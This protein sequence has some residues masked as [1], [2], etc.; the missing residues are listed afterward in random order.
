MPSATD[1]APPPVARP[2]RLRKFT[3]L[4][5][6]ALALLA[7]L[8]VGFY[9]V[10]K[11]RGRALWQRYEA[12]ARV[13]GVKLMLADYVPPPVPDAKNFAVIPL[14]E[15]AFRAQAAGHAAPNPFALPRLAGAQQ[16]RKSPPP[17]PPLGQPEKA[18]VVDLA[19]WQRFFV[20]TKALPAATDNAAAD[21]MKALERYAE[22]LEQ[23][24]AAGAR[25]ACRFP[26][27]WEDGIHAALPHL[28]M[29]R[30]AA[31]IYALRCAAHLALGDSAA[32]YEDFRGVLR[33]YTATAQEPSLIAGLA[34]VAI[35]TTAE[36]AV[37]TGL[38]GRQWADAE[39]RRIGDD[40][41]PLRLFADYR[42]GMSSERGFSN[43]IHEQLRGMSG[44]KIHELLTTASAP[45][46]PDQASVNGQARLFSAFPCG[47][48]YRSQERANRYF[49]EMLERVSVEPPRVF[50]E[51]VVKSG[52]EQL[53]GTSERLRHLFFFLL[54]PALNSVEGT[55]ARAQTFTDQTRLACA[56]ELHRRAHGAF[57][58]T[59][60]AL[61]PALL[62]ALLRDV[63]NGEPLRYRVTEGG[64]YLLYSVA[65]NLADDGGKTGPEPN[66]H[67][68]DWVWRMP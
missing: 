36:N 37:W 64:G 49:D 46:P 39:L 48:I 56:L 10:E 63:M 40:L 66:K 26:V 19:A 47:W 59:L 25:P 8:I 24:R 52:P 67:Q 9:V 7:T 53:V 45:T 14:F 68:P 22:P 61:A 31:K 29:L 13:R 60:D 2:S 58:A 4:A 38:F 21:V 20:E 44:A 65:W 42:L 12:E 17:P 55:Y 15:E 35:L 62:P 32:A 54:A 1:P 6:F 57:P 27:R 50:A 41:A 43:M 5:A 18:R 34:R 51:R 30:D 11:Q 23:L 28:S 33:L 16:P 3:T